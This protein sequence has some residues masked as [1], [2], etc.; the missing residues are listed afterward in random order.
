[1][2]DAIRAVDPHQPFSAFATMDEVKANAFASE[3]RQMSLLGGL[4]AIGLLLATAGIYGLIAYTVAQRTREFGLRVALGATRG[5]IL[6]SI[7][8]SGALTASV[9]I[10]VGLIASVAFARTLDSFV[11][12]VSTVHIPTLAAV[13]ALLLVV[14]MLAT[15]VPAIRATRLNPIAALR[16]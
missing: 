9:G 8:V 10:V 7:V 1:M 11:W 15:L 14:S 4:A 16:E 3:R 5:R 2:R 13:A 12:G 6:R